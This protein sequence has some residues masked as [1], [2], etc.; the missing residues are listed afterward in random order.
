VSEGGYDLTD[1]YKVSLKQL[2]KGLQRVLCNKFICTNAAPFNNPN[3]IGKTEYTTQRDFGRVAL[4]VFAHYLFGHVDAT[5]AI[6][7]DLTFVKSILSISSDSAAVDET[8]AGPAARYTAYNSTHL[9]EI[10]SADISQWTNKTGSISDANLAK[11]LTAAIIEKGFSAGTL[12]ESNVQTA[13]T[14]DLAHIV[15]Q[16]VG[17]DATRL[18]NEDNSERSGAIHQLLRFYEGDIIY[19]KIK[20]NTPNVSVSS[21]Q[22]GGVTKSALESS[23]NE[24]SYILK[25]IL[26]PREVL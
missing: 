8:I 10:N 9:S 3:Y 6:T 4:A 22:V 15:R 17:Q 5:A 25:I 2:A 21:G 23:Y 11:R 1:S 19:V 24:K 13:T 26:G 14:S 20:L 12:V 18:M 16:V 7:N